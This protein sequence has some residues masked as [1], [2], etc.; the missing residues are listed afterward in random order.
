MLE[1]S[2]SLILQILGIETLIQNTNLLEVLDGES[3]KNNLLE[4]LDGESDKN[5]LL[6]MLKS[7]QTCHYFN[8][9]TSRQ[10]SFS[11]RHVRFLFL[12]V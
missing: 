3:D 2:K 9:N 1:S 12:A 10:W 7:L 4:V 6:E 5:N 8:Y 11:Q